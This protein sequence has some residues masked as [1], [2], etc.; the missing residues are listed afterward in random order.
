MDTVDLAHKLAYA[1]ARS[2][3]PFTT[4]PEYTNSVPAVPVLSGVRIFVP[5]DQWTDENVL[6]LATEICRVLGPTAQFDIGMTL[7]GSPTYDA[8]HRAAGNIARLMK[9]DADSPEVRLLIRGEETDGA[10]VARYPRLAFQPGGNDYWRT[11]YA[12]A[13]V[14]LPYQE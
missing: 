3:V 2:P 10:Y 13:A 6:K 7:E 14:K 1:G 11:I 4:G 9:L 8:L 12:T 5:P